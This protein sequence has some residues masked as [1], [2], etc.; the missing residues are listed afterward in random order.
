M[1]DEFLQYR[2]DGLSNALTGLGGKGDRAQATRPATRLTLTTEEVEELLKDPTIER[3]CSAYPEDATKKKVEFTVGGDKEGEDFSDEQ[4]GIR[5]Y[6]ETVAVRQERIDENFLDLGTIASELDAV[7][8]AQFLA[9]VYGGAGVLIDI[10]DGQDPSEPIA[11]KRIKTIR[12]LY[13][14]DRWQLT[15]EARFTYDWTNPTHY[16][17]NFGN[18]P[19]GLNN[20]E[21]ISVVHRSRVLRFDGRNGRRMPSRVLQQNNGWG[22]SSIDAVWEVWRDYTT[23]F[24]YLSNMI[25]DCSFF[26]YKLRG[27]RAMI[28]SGN[29]DRLRKRFQNLRLS[30]D[31]LGG[32]ALGRGRHSVAD[33]DFCWTAG[34]DRSIQGFSGRSNGDAVVD[35]LWARGDGACRSR[36]W[37]NGGKDLG[38]TGRKL[39]IFGFTRQAATSISFNL[40]SQ[41]WPNGGQGS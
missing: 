28:E 13:V 39:S 9:N 41:G 7:T 3:I 31:V 20:D 12:G 37:G 24:Q 16:R 21:P 29:E 22:Q 17:L 19:E 18:R 30:A 1:S 38:G 36:D 11:A 33:P 34:T 32:A 5:K 35:H 4:E 14:L 8:Q 25:A 27:L 40:A 2:E 23:V 26:V 6:C 10:D 15:P